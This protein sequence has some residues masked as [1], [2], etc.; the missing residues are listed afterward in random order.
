MQRRLPAVGAH[1]PERAVL[2]IDLERRD[3]PE[4]RGL[5][6]GEVR[7]VLRELVDD[8]ELARLAVADDEAA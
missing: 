2:R 1:D 3:F 4:P 5:R 8:G 6:A 7:D